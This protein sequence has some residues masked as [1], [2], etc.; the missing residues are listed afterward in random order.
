MQ[1]DVRS[2]RRL[3]VYPTSDLSPDHPLAQLAMPGWS[4]ND[5]FRAVHD[6]VGHAAT[7]FQFGP[8]GE[9]NAYRFHANVHSAAATPAL[10][11]ETRLQN[12]WVNF[13]PHL[14]DAQGKNPDTKAFQLSIQFCR[15]DYVAIMDHEP[16]RMVE[17]Q[18]LAELLDG[19]GGGRVFRHFL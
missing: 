19:L 6:L 9:E 8:V 14:R 17:G 15:E 12:C 2:K 13:G 18:K 11:A 3:F 1:A 16:V 10:A 4:W 7:G 5:V